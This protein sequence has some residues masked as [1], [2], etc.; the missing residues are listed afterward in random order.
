MD[1]AQRT[2]AR[3][4]APLGA[5]LVARG[6]ETMDGQAFQSGED[7]ASPGRIDIHAGDTTKP[8]LVE[9]A[10]NAP[11]RSGRLADIDA[12]PTAPEDVHIS[13]SPQLPIEPLIE[14]A[15]L[16]VDTP[17]L[18]PLDVPTAPLKHTILKVIAREAGGQCL[19]RE[20]LKAGYR[21]PNMRP[22]EGRQGPWS[23]ALDCGP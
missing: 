7:A 19:G 17:A 3:P 22:T 12:L 11:A 13:P 21:P 2:P 20:V 15:A 1:G 5:E 6:L 10:G 23:W 16:G 18:A 8:V 4:L 9:V 14:G